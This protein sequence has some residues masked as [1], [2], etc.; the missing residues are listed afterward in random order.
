MVSTEVISF[1]D[2]SSVLTEGVV[3]NFIITRLDEQK[4]SFTSTV[5]VVFVKQR[6]LGVLSKI[7]IS[8]TLLGKVCLSGLV[9]RR[10][11]GHRVREKPL[12]SSGTSEKGWF[13]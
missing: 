11:K 4:I 6:P 7:D 3:Y 2:L 12:T 8:T 13:G 5:G 1:V 10:A 9:G